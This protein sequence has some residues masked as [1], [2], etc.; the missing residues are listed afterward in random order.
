MT[1]ECLELKLMYFRTSFCLMA[2]V[3]NEDADNPSNFAYL[4]I[5]ILSN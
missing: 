1:V 2:T 4:V 5:A 3:M